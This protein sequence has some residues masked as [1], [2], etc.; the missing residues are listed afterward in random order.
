M[1][2]LG[3]ELTWIDKWKTHKKYE[4]ANHKHYCSNLDPKIELG[5]Y[6]DSPCEEQLHRKSSCE[7]HCFICLQSEIPS[8][9]KTSISAGKLSITETTRGVVIEFQM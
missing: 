8:L 2:E 3:S 6:E 5:K 1:T 7:A 4:D 9:L